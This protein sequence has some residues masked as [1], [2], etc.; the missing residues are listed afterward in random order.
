ME[1]KSSD[2]RAGEKI[3][4]ANNDGE[5][6]QGKAAFP[7][8]GAAVKRLNFRRFVSHTYTH[9]LYTGSARYSAPTLCTAGARYTAPTLY[10]ASARYTAP[11]L[12][13]AGARYTAPTLYTASAR[14]TAPTL[15]K[16]SARYMHCT[17]TFN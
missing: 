7:S 3:L 12:C 2:T 11:T 16:P 5:R 13:T 9:T 1:S 4:L 10:T 14:Y 8:L 15:Y 6:Q 17:H